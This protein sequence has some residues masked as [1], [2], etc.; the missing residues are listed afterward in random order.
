MGE[1][2]EIMDWCKGCAKNACKD[3]TEAMT[4]RHCL[5]VMLR[6]TSKEVHAF[7]SKFIT[8]TP[9][10]WMPKVELQVCEKCGK[11]VVSEDKISEVHPDHRD[12]VCECQI[13]G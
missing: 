13:N 3:W 7:D 10:W 2:K 6:R 9:Q 8:T 1:V 12:E 4:C 5:W 11:V